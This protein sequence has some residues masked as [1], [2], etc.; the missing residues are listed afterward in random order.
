[1][2]V[3]QEIGLSSV[4]KRTARHLLGLSQVTDTVEGIS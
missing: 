4:L 1:V 2:Q 3:H